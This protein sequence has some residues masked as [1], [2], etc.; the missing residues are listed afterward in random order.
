RHL[1]DA[2]R[3]LL[4]QAGAAVLGP[5]LGISAYV[6]S[7]GHAGH[8]P[9]HGLQQLDL[10]YLDEP[11]PGV[12]ATGRPVVLVFCDGCTP[13]EVTGAAVEVRDDPALAAR[14]G[15]GAPGRRGYALVDGR[16]RVRYR[17]YDPGLG[18]HGVEIQTLVDAV[19]GR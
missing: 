11:A 9:Q 15:L 10:L 12:P 16:G 3:R 17:T 4:L 18:E 8:D 19:A 7:P 6:L 13:P 1:V 2:R 14:Y 5:V